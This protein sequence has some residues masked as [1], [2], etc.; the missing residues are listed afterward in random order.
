MECRI[1]ECHKANYSKGLCRRHYERQKKYGNAEEPDRKPGRPRQTC[2]MD[3]CDNNCAANGLCDKHRQRLAK[4]GDPLV[5]KR[6]IG[7]TEAR[8][9]SHVDR[10]GD[11]ECWPWTS[12]I[13]NAGYGE[14]GVGQ[15]V[16]KA[17]I[18][19]YEHFVKQV[20]RG[21]H[22]DHVKANG[23]TMRHCVNYLHHL[24]PVTNRENVLRGNRTKLSDSEVLVLY[25]RWIGGDG[26][27]DDLAEESGVHRTTL[28][29]RFRR[30]RGLTR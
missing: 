1:S 11:D 2:S 14:F 20:P 18:W 13:N 12:T 23:C 3:G 17:H 5:T 8:W 27:V 15:K 30:I 25:G 9:W 6:I 4:H 19:G 29:R 26:P 10:R 28:F 7:D 24:E 21:L 22:L 16:L